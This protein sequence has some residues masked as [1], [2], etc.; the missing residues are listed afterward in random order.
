[1]TTYSPIALIIKEKMS[2]MPAE[3]VKR[4]E[5]L[6]ELEGEYR[7]KARQAYRQA[8]QYKKEEKECRKMIDRMLG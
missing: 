3:N 6:V 5:Q 1:M 4:I 2:K 7:L 8:A